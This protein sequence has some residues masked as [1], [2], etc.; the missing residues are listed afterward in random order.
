M[1]AYAF[2]VI[3]D[4]IPCTYKEEVQSVENA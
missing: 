4:G 3:D 2:I 1:V